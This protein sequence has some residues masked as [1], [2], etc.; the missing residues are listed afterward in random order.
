[1]AVDTSWVGQCT[2]WVWENLSWIRGKVNGNAMN[3]AASAQ[4]N[5][6]LVNKTPSVG[7]AV[8]WGPGNGYSS[9]GHVAVVTSVDPSG[10]GGFTVSEMNYK[11]WNQTD[12]RY[13]PNVNDV[14]GFIH[15]PG[16]SGTNAPVSYTAA[17]QDQNAS[18]N[19]NLALH[20][21]NGSVFGIHGGQCLTLAEVITQGNSAGGAS[22]VAGY[23]SEV[24][25]WLTQPCKWI[26]WGLIVVGGIL[27]FKGLG[28]LTNGK[29]TQVVVAPFKAAGKA[30]R[31]AGTDAAVAA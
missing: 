24:G 31:A 29:S 14:L 17:L 23:V 2:Y 10:S 8:V 21:A 30:G 13:I 20:L 3:W 19:Q 5:G 25:T 12:T 22:G 16:T 15:A 9:V 11:G 4:S 7:S 26:M 28:M 27:V 1:M 18:T 6:L